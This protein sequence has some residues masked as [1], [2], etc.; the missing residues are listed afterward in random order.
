[1]VHLES[2]SD[3]QR[4][5]PLSTDEMSQSTF[6]RKELG[7]L[8]SGYFLRNQIYPCLISALIK[9]FKINQLTSFTISWLD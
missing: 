8:A 4:P 7:N 6:L 2:W 1:M 5:P 9:I 3:I